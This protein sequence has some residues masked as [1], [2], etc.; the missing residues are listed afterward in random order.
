[1]HGVD[2]QGAPAAVSSAG[3]RF[4]D[5]RAAGRRLAARLGERPDLKDAVVLGVAYG[6]VPV[7]FEVARGLGLPLDLVHLRRLLV[8]RG[9]LDPAC[10]VSVAGSL[11]LDEDLTARADTRDDVKEKFVAGAVEEFTARARDSRGGRPAAS[12]KGRSVLLV[13]NG[14]RTGSTMRV[15]LRALRTREP[16]RVVVAVPVAAPEARAA[17]EPLADE[18]FSLHW[19]QPFGHVGLWYA[20]LRRPDDAEVRALLKNE[21]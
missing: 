13:D 14:I 20:A 19:P 5:P 8:P 1:M 15:A 3:P 16:A 7:A 11:F 21:E 10:A 9:H 12:L 4:A 2:A 18:L 17:V 6:G